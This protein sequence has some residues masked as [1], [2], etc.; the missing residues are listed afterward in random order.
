VFRSATKV[1]IRRV[2]LP[3]IENAVAL[4]AE[5][6]AVERDWRVFQRNANPLDQART[7]YRRLIRTGKGKILVA[8]M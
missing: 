6:D 5:L 8:E 3:D 2:G 7:R 4:F 1:T